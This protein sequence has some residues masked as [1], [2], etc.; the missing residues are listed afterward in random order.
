MPS[1]AHNSL[2]GIQ[3]GVTN[4]YYHL[5]SSLY[6]VLTAA[7]TDTLIGRDA[8]SSGDVTN[9]TLAGSL[10]FTGSN[11]IQL[12]NDAS[13]PGASKYYGTNASSTKGFFSLPTY[14]S[15]LTSVDSSN[16][17]INITSPTT[18][19]IITAD[20]IATGVIAG[21]YG[22]ATSIPQ[23]TVDA[24]GR[25]T[26]ATTVA[27]SLS[28]GSVSGLDEAIDDR[29]NSLLVAGTNITLTYNDPANTLTINSTAGGVSG[30]GGPLEVAYWNLTGTAITSTPSFLFDGTGMS[31]NTPS[32][33][34]NVIL[35]TKGLTTG[36]SSWGYQ[37]LDAVDNIV[38]SVDDNGTLYVGD[39]SGT[40]L[41]ISNGGILKAG[42]FYLSAS[43]GD[44]D[45]TTVSGLV[46]ID[47]DVRIDLGSDATGDIFTRN[48]SGNLQ[49][50]AAGTSGYVLT[51]N[52]TGMLP[53]WQAAG[54]GGGSLPGGTTG[55]ILVH[56]GTDYQSVSRV[57]ETQTGIT[58]TAVTLTSTPL[59]Y[60]EFTLYKNGLYQIVT[61]DFSRSGA[62]ITMVA[63]LTTIDRITAIYYL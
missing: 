10:T 5:R 35:T 24:N 33:P 21:T 6:N 43:T 8:A 29:V 14:V 4:E 3:G 45:I 2:S 15:S 7:G 26:S 42:S 57:V 60:T 9:I 63:S 55:D 22:N 61:D 49:R 23:I 18:T 38:F 59:T 41:T 37:H 40:P 12:T 13:S 50:I 51:S 39:V 36:A 19:P 44:I 52:G 47:S 16:I 31:I 54:G 46:H 20:L 58:G 30:T 1:A 28:A 48:S 25:L 11:S 27:L 32:V 53:T 17:D 62:S 56:D 34:L